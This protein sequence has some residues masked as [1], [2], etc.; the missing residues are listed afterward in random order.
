[1]FARRLV[2]AGSAGAVL[3]GL[4]AFGCDRLERA[5]PVVEKPGAAV[6][7]AESD[8]KSCDDFATRLCSQTANELSTTCI[9]IRTTVDLLAPEACGLALANAEHSLQALSKRDLS[10]DALQAK[11]CADTGAMEKSCERVKK[12]TGKFPP[13]RCKEMLGRYPDV[14]A[15]LKQARLGQ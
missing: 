9:A 1:M 12:F 11:L 5:N 3:L 10:C 15:D 13:E 8:R 6:E 4:A 14:L 2:V 7:L